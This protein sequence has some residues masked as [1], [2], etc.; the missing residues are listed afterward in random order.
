M[1]NDYLYD[2]TRMQ[3]EHPWGCYEIELVLQKIP[4]PTWRIDDALELLPIDQPAENNERISGVLSLDNGRQIMVSPC[5]GE[6]LLYADPD[7][8]PALRNLVNDGLFWFHTFA[9]SNGVTGHGMDPSARK[10]YHLCLPTRLNGLSV[11]DV[12][13]YEGFFSF[14]MEQRGAGRVVAADEYVWNEPGSPAR[15]HFD[16]I[17]K[18]LKS[19]IEDISTSIENLSLNIKEQFDIVLFLRL[20]SFT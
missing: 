5:F 20:I 9:F 3:S 2:Y 16:G 1:D 15:R 13:A 17:R 19:E 14:H 12:G 4:K 10:L 11:L 6:T 8:A 18:A 7:T